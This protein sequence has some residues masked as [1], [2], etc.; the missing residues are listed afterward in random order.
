MFLIVCLFAFSL[1]PAH[2]QECPAPSCLETEM[3]ATIDAHVQE[4]MQTLNIPGMALAIVRDGEIIYLKGYGRADDSGRAMTP[5]TP[6]VLA[7]VSKSFT[8]LAVMQ[9]VE[10]GQIDLDAPV[11][12]YLPWFTTANPE[13]A[14]R[15]RVRDLV[16]QTSG[17]STSI[18]REFNDDASPNALENT[19]R[20]LSS[21]ELVAEPGSDIF[22]YSNTN[23]DILGLIVQVVS[24]QSYSDYIRARIYEPLVMTRSYTV[25]ELDA[26]Q[27]DGL[28]T[29]YTVFFGGVIPTQFYFPVAQAPSGGL[30]S[31]AEDLAHYVQM[32]LNGGE[33]A[34]NQLLS[35]DGIAALHRPGVIYDAPLFGYAMGWNTSWLWSAGTQDDGQITVPALVEHDGWTAGFRTQI[36][37]MPGENLG[38]VTLMNSDDYSRV[39]GYGHMGTGIAHLLFGVPAGTMRIFEDL[40]VQNLRPVLLG[41]IAFLGFG[42]VWS[43]FNLRRW[44]REPAARPRG[45]WWVLRA[46]VLPLLIDIGLA[47]GLIVAL[48]AAND[49]SV[50]DALRATPEFVA[51]FI[52]LL[53]LLMWGVLRTGL[54]AAALRSKT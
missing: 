47:Y 13:Q 22:N 9:L 33:Y 51:L 46:V 48:P 34:G 20:S 45:F 11:T 26:A 1:T 10:A 23:Y 35:A 5:Q 17:F 21:V 30:I 18:G 27:S 40:L 7:S 6:F 49:V 32:H 36:M 19:V 37:L 28:T 43:I 52:P 53:I 39:S 14:A 12:T 41:I 29:G 38:I 54:Y 4:T 44:Q 8:A 3:A 16:Y 15:I 24:G 31:T 50:M 25:S 2:A 42:V